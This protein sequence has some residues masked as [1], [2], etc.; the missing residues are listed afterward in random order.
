MCEAVKIKREKPE[1][2]PEMKLSI[3][4]KL[5]PSNEIHQSAPKDKDVQ[6]KKGM[7]I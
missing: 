1:I 6:T 2:K 5:R 3:R 4:D 7:E